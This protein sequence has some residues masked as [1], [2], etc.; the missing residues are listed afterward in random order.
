MSLSEV[1]TE[2]SKKITTLM[3]ELTTWRQGGRSA[4]NQFLF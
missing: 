4:E 1:K 2:R 3:E